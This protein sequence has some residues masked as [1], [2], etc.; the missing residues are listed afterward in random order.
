MCTCRPATKPVSLHENAE[1]SKGAMPVAS[2]MTKRAFAGITCSRVLPSALEGL[3]LTLLEA[4]AY[5]T[6][7]VASD[8]PP[9][10]EVLHDDGPGHR[11]FRAGSQ[12]S[13]LEALERSFRDPPAETEGAPK[14][15]DV[16]LSTYRWES[17]V[18]DTERLYCHVL[19]PR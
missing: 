15:R 19:G 11:L 14:L 13:L 5:G 8:I 17:V 9:H 18:D 1:G 6:P 12:A 7:I 4:A 2:R 16:V 10:L 3:P